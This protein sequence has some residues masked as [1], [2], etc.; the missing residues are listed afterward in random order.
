MGA[1]G[2]DGDDEVYG[3]GNEFGNVEFV[4]VRLPMVAQVTVEVF[5]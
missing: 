3:D 4:K 1:R 2:D 5:V